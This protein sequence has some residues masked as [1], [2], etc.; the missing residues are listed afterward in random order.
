M[1]LLPTQLQ[2]SMTHALIISSL[3]LLMK[4]VSSRVLPPCIKYSYCFGSIQFVQLSQK[5]QK[6]QFDMSPGKYSNQPVHP[7][8]LIRIFIIRSLTKTLVRLHGYT[9][10][11][12]PSLGAHDSFTFCYAIAH[13]RTKALTPPFWRK[14]EKN[15]VYVIL[16][17]KS[18]I[19]L[20][21]YCQILL[22]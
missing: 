3:P 10:C 15:M 16:I 9:G 6:V 17:S 18:Y 7:T 19:S 5:Q 12:E 14:V 13:L 1:H 22:S 11:S 20:K 8:I 2:T 21:A 4:I